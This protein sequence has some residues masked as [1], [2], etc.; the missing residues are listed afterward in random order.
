MLENVDQIHLVQASGKQVLQKTKIAEFEAQTLRSKIKK[1]FQGFF[2]FLSDPL[3]RR[4]KVRLEQ[5][6]MERKSLGYHFHGQRDFEKRN[7]LREEKKI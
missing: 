1:E 2:F 6:Q 3:E 4:K 7:F 5:R